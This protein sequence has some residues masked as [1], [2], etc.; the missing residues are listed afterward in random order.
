MLESTPPP[1]TAHPAHTGIVKRVSWVEL[2]FDLIFVFAVGQTAHTIVAEP[3]WHATGLAVLLFVALWWTWIGFVVLYDRI[4]TETVAGR[5]VVLA[6]T[7]PCAIA[8]IQVHDAAHGGTAG[9]AIALAATRVLLALAF[10]VSG[11]E[12]S[13]ARATM[14]GYLLSAAIFAVSAAVPA[15]WRYLL[16]GIVLFQ[17]AGLLLLGPGRRNGNRWATQLYRVVSPPVTDAGGVEALRVDP[18]H[19]A[20]R[21]GQFMIILLGE[22][23][24]AVGTEASSTK[25]HGTSYWLVLIC[26]LVIPAALWWVYFTSAVGINESLLRRS[27]G[28]PAIAYS[29][30]AGGHLLPA[31]SLLF[32]AAGISVAI[33]EE[34][35]SIGAWL[36]MIGLAGFML[37][38][39]AVTDPA[40]SNAG[41]ILRL[42][43]AAATVALALLRPIVSAAGIVLIAAAYA[44][45]AAAIVSLRHTDRVHDIAATRRVVPPQP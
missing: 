31:C 12:R 35:A 37:G 24:I 33:G 28:D 15:P 38:A 39:R 4:G 13:S 32:L 45:S 1:V 17:E 5:L 20:E 29:L 40:T 30:Y 43:I 42:V 3:T 36:I 16:W 7:V 19:L 23:V 2:Y 26:G 34:S 22:I 6:G 9:F 27:G 44:L 25:H 14:I 10:R 41:R 18:F 21:F 8:A 11:D